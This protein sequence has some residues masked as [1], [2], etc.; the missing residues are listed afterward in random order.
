P[1]PYGTHPSSFFAAFFLNL[2]PIG[3]NDE[4]SQNHPDIGTSTQ[5]RSI[6]HVHDKSAPTGGRMILFICIIGSRGAALATKAGAIHWALRCGSYSS[7]SSFTACARLSGPP[8]F[9]GNTI[10]G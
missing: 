7:L 3:R 5:G 4:V 2:T 1:R 8:T 10:Y 6:G 9:P